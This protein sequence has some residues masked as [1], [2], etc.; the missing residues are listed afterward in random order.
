MHYSKSRCTE[1]STLKFIE[2][3]LATDWPGVNFTKSWSQLDKINNPVVCA[4][5]TDTMYDRKELGNTQYRERYMLVIDIFATSD[6]MRIDLTDWL[7]NTLNPGWDYCE[8]S[9]DSGNRRQLV[10]TPTGRCRIQ[11]ILNNTR[12]DLGEFGDVKDKYRQNIVLEITVG[13]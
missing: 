3:N 7:M 13:C 10:Y 11:Y 6:G 5:L 12:M 1:L 8:V 2:D 9:L 4:I